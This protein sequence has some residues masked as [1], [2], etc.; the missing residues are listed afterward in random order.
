MGSFKD[1][2]LVEAKRAIESTISKCEK[3]L[4]KLKDKSAQQ[5]LMKR[6]IKAFSIS[7]ELIE[8]ELSQSEQTK[9]IS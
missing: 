9:A 7:V 4:P 8:R 2:E 6:R 5:T 3:A 1:I